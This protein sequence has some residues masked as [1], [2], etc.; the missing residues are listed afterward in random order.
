MTEVHTAFWTGD[1]RG[2]D[3]EI[4]DGTH[5]HEPAKGRS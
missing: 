4:E 1:L 2:L 3:E 5:V